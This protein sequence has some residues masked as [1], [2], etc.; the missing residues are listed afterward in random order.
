MK[1][2]I[3]VY[4]GS[5]AAALAAVTAARLGRSVVLVSPNGHLGGLSSGGL[6][7]TD[8][9]NEAVVGGLGREFY[10][11][12]G[13]HYGQDL[14]WRFEPHVAERI[15]EDWVHGAGL[16]P[17]RNLR[18]IKARKK[19][20]RIEA[21][22]LDDGR[23]V[24]ASCFIDCSYE[25][26]LMA[27]A[28]VGYTV[29]REAVAQYGEDLSGVRAES[30][31]HQFE[32][33]VDPYVKPG[34]PASGLLPCI[35]EGDGGKPGAG[36]RLVQA[37]NFRLCLTQVEKNRIPVLPSAGY[38]RNRYALLGRTL[39]VLAKK[40]LTPHFTD[41]FL[42]VEMPNHKTDFNNRGFFSTDHIGANWAY[43]DAGH[44]ERARIWA[45]HEAY[46]RGLF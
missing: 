14:A 25:G 35:Q 43:P 6:G 11:T 12:L 45:D 19:G 42:I 2:D 41:L 31:S 3:C 15:F 27:M 1:A 23:E 8:V 20:A 46:M 4:G 22:S 40:G 9:G 37:Y 7:A 36:D 44:A 30:P 38:D 10:K 39:E 18:C 29:G 32:V 28:G 16:V 21:I 13:S 26:D 34:N 5:S 24:E 17:L 33:D